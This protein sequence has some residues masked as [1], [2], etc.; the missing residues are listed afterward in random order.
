MHEV[1]SRKCAYLPHWLD[2]LLEQMIV[3]G[4]GQIVRSNEVVVK[5]PEFFHGS[6][7]A[8]LLDVL[9]VILLCAHAL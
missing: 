3:G 5:G 1:A 7:R 6:K 2:A 9:L 4:V 8:N